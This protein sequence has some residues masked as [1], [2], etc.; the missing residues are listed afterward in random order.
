[1]GGYRSILAAATE[2]QSRAIAADLSGPI[3]HSGMAAMPRYDAVQHRPQITVVW[4]GLSSSTK[5]SRRRRL[6]REPPFRCPWANE[7][8]RPTAVAR[9]G[10][11]LW[12]VHSPAAEFATGLKMRCRGVFCRAT[13]HAKASKVSRE[14]SVCAKTQQCQSY[15]HRQPHVE[16]SAGCVLHC[17]G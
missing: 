1:M 7:S 2:V 16:R 13:V 4:D 14:C 11:R 9:G 5:R 8:N 6:R 12:A 10:D 3:G 17:F 15:L